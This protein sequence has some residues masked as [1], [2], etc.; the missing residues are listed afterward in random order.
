MPPGKKLPQKDIRTLIE[1]ISW[2]CRNCAEA[3]G[4]PY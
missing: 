4:P 2:A 3:I 1:W